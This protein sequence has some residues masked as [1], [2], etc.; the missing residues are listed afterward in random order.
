MRVLLM[1]VSGSVRV[2]GNVRFDL[3]FFLDTCIKS[4]TNT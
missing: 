4:D 3:F 1:Q 2:I